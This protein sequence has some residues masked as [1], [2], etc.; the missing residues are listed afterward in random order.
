[1]APIKIVQSTLIKFDPSLPEPTKTDLAREHEKRK[2]IKNDRRYHIHLSN[3]N[4][5]EIEET[6]CLDCG[7]RLVKN[8]F[9]NRIT[10]RANGIG[11]TDLRV[12]RRRCPNCGEIRPDY[13]R[14]Y[15]KN[16]RYHE[17]FPRKARQYYKEGFLPSQVGSIFKIDFQHSFEKLKLSLAIDHLTIFLFRKSY[18]RLIS[19]S[20]G[21]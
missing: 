11:R 8:G 18:R 15:T 19:S 20:I 9:N 16:C 5:V 17:N 2:E 4:N 10:I 6:H 3:N 1:M 14:L 21:L 12:N 7:S 13:S